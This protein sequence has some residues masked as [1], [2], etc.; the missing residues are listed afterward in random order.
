MSLWEPR[1]RSWL[2]GFC[3]WRDAVQVRAFAARSFMKFSVCCT[4]SKGRS[5]DLWFQSYTLGTRTTLKSL[6]LCRSC[7]YPS[8]SRF[9]S[10]H[11]DAHSEMKLCL[12]SALIFFFFLTF[13]F[14]LLSNC[15]A[16]VLTEGSCLSSSCNTAAGE[17]V[18]I[19]LRRKGSEHLQFCSASLK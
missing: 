2:Q 8:L 15:F 17:Y 10:G 13:C 16:D 18:C 5:Q 12:I 11:T 19:D 7:H 1:E 14:P 4:Y 3:C 9:C 6:V